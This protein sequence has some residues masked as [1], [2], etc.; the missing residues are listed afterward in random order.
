[1]VFNDKNHEFHGQTSRTTCL[2]YSSEAQSSPM[3]VDATNRE[4]QDRDMKCWLAEAQHRVPQAGDAKAA[5]R[6]HVT[7]RPRYGHL[8]RSGF[9]LVEMLIVISVASVMMGISVCAIHLLLDAEHEAARAVRFNNSVARLTHAFRSDMH[10]SRQVDLPESKPGKPIV[11][12]ATVDGGQVRYELEAH[13]ATRIE[14]EGEQQVHREVYYFPPYS[15]MRF[16]HQPSQGLVVLKIDMAAGG[17][18]TTTVPPAVAS[19][20]KRPLFIEAA[21]GRDH[22]FERQK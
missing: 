4:S 21:L 12:V 2:P 5:E 14:L 18:G 22:R 6:Q 13:L 1:M 10:A 15:Q 19:G 11:L 20:T 7:K 9:T 3:Q 8:S 16:E 17:S